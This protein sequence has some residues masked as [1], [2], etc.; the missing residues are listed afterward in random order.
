MVSSLQSTFVHR[1]NSD[2]TIDSICRECLLTVAS[3]IWETELEHAEHDHSCDPYRLEY[4]QKLAQ[5]PP[6]PQSSTATHS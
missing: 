5:N 1:D 3:A 2:G 6:N 4:L